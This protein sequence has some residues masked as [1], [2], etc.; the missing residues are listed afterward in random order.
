VT[1]PE[2][3][4][5]QVECRLLV[6]EEMRNLRGQ[7]HGGVL[8]SLFD[9]TMSAAANRCATQSVT[10]VDLHVSYCAPAY[11]PEVV[12]RARAVA[13]GS[14]VIRCYAEATAGPQVVGVAIGTWARAS[15]EPMREHAE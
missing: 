12:C 13:A 8:A 15:V 5:D 9:V 4:G 10:T 7:A 14:S 1:S 2:D 6:R 3:I 11:G